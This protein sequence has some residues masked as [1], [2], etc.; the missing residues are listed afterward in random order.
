MLVDTMTTHCFRTP[1]DL[2]EAFERLESVGIT[3]YSWS[4]T[5]RMFWRGE[6][7]FNVAITAKYLDPRA[8]RKGQQTILL[9]T[10]EQLHDFVISHDFA[11]TVERMNV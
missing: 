1:E 4:I 5:K 10:K 2:C 7:I 9:I 8:Q 6:R 11:N 3:D